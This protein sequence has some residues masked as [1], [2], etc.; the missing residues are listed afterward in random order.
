MQVTDRG[1]VLAGRADTEY[2]SIC[3]PGVCVTPGGR[4]LV[5]LRAA[6]T[7]QAVVPQRTLLVRSDD[8]GATWSDPI[9]P[10]RPPAVP[11]RQGRFRAGHLTALGGDRLLAVAYWVDVSD[12]S[13]PFFNE[14]TE[15]LADSRVCTSLSAD[16]GATW[17]E[18]Q[19]VDTSPYSMP[20]AIT[21]PALLL[22]DGEWALQFETNKT[23][24]DPSPWHH[25]SV[26]MFSAD[27]GRTWP[28]HVCVAADPAGRVFYWDQRPGVLPGGRVLDLFWTF[29]RETAEYLNIHARLSCDHGRSWSEIWD[30]GV[31]GQPAPP[32]ALPDGR[33][34]MVYVDR[35]GPPQIKVRLTADGGRTWPEEIEAVV[36]GESLASQSR[37]KGSMQD[38]WA[39]MGRFSV[40]L[41]ATAPLPD[42]ELLVV[43][44]AGP[45]TDL[46]DVQWARLRPG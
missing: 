27:E 20:T 3:F 21:G 4:W 8:S 13:L 30:I 18:P 33:L 7:K 34:A 15:G 29:D 24:Y 36:Y 6:P 42:G 14:E 25:E 39:E 32:V 44:Y 31:P 26:L 10:W 1:T 35:T 5:T 41:P 40:G 17:S 11:G 22:E 43:Y 46:T 12:P 45:Q 2:S 19:F 28:G 16:G 38:A 23:Y 9:E 37:D